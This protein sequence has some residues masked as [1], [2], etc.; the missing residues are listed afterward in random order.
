[1]SGE[2]TTNQAATLEKIAVLKQVNLKRTSS[3]VRFLSAPVIQDIIPGLPVEF[4]IR[5]TQANIPVFLLNL[6]C[7]FV[8][9]AK[10]L[11]NIYSVSAVND[12]NR[13]SSIVFLLIEVGEVSEW[14]P[15]NCFV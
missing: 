8:S 4:M 2:A 3:F 6:V 11:W 9:P 12:A 13:L 1:M 7:F 5:S 15:M 14:L 10:G